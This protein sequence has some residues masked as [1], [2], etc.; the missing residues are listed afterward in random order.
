MP[1]FSEGKILGI[2]ASS[3]VV[4]MTRKS[5]GAKFAVKI[6]KRDDWENTILF[7]QEYELLTQLK[8]PNILTFEDCYMDRENFYI[9]TT[10]CKG[11]ELF[12]KIREIRTFTEVEAA[13]VMKVIISAIAYCHAKDIVHRDLKPENI[14]FRDEAQ[15]ELVIID[16]G[17]A[18]QIDDYKKYEDFVGTAFWLAPE[19]VRNRRGWELKKSDMWT[20]GIITFQLLTGRLPFH[21]RDIQEI[22]RK[23]LRGNYS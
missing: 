22:L 14:V 19:C 8:H 12:D 4:Q 18:I 9:C 20:I 23:I 6:L 17:E 15:K 13:R 16:F 5:D 2:G 21:G 7:R 1:L 10:L 11:G 3:K